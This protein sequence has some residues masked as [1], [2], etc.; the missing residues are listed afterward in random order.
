MICKVNLVMRLQS[1]LMEILKD[2]I[3][4]QS[5]CTNLLNAEL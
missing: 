2:G 4:A 3:E 1:D 5:E